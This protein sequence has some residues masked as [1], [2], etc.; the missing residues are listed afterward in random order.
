MGLKKQ[1]MIVV[2]TTFTS[3]LSLVGLAY[4]L[5]TRVSPSEEI[6]KTVTPTVTLTAT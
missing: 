2:L 5:I 4:V 6:D 1:F 3:L